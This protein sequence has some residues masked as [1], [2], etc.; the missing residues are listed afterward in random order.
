MQSE[1]N[2]RSRRTHALF[3][4]PQI[5]GEFT[6]QLGTAL[7]FGSKRFSYLQRRSRS[8]RGFEM[9]LRSRRA[10]E[11]SC[12]RSRCD[13]QAGAGSDFLH[14]IRKY[15]H[16]TSILTTGKESGDRA[17]GSSGEVKSSDHPITRS[18][19]SASR[20]AFTMSSIICLALEF[21]S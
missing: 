9:N 8:G 10:V 16:K 20:I 19:Y 11:V 7:D 12:G 21:P 1:K 17:I 15:G 14:V 3:Q 5:A 13:L 18:V 2:L 4:R 6:A